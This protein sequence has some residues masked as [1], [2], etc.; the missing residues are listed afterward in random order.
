MPALALALL[1]ALAGAPP[2]E[3]VLIPAGLLTPSELLSKQNPSAVQITNVGNAA[4]SFQHL[5]ETGQWRTSTISPGATMTI[6]CPKCGGVIRFAYDDGHAVQQFQAVTG[7]AYRFFWSAPDT[8]W[9]LAPQ[10]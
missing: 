4:L 9:R 6:D 1:A 5:D 3:A 10:P 2:S 7:R 8:A